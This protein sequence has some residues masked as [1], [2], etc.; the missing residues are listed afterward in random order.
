MPLVYERAFGGLGEAN[1][2]GVETPNV[3]DPADPRNPVSFAPISPYW[4]ARK[5][6][7][8]RT[9]RR[10]FEG[11]PAEVPDGI[12]WE[13]FQAAPPD[14]QTDHL[15]GG[16]WLVLDGVHPTL[17]RVQ[18]RLPTARGVARVLV[19]RPGA[20]PA[21][22][23]VELACDTLTIDGEK[24]M[25]SL[26]WRGHYEV[27]GGDAA[28]SSLTVLAGLEEVNAVVD[29]AKL[30]RPPAAPA[31]G[32]SPA[33]A[34][35]AAPAEETLALGS[36]QAAAVAQRAIAP[37]AVAAA[38]TRAVPSSTAATPWSADPVRAIAAVVG[39][40]TLAP[41][42]AQSPREAVGEGTLPLR[43]EQHAALAQ[44]PIAPF[45]LAAP[46]ARGTSAAVA[47]A[48]WSGRRGHCA[49]PDRRRRR[50]DDGA[51]RPAWP[52]QSR[53]AAFGA[54]VSVRRAADTG[55][56]PSTPGAE[57]RAARGTGVD[58]REV[59]RSRRQPR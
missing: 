2:V 22:H 18:T 47:G 55:D 23:V 54:R 1:P 52:V 13:Y 25:I 34:K 24:Q 50:G 32:A 45:Q 7:L 40:V 11:A 27:A 28:L 46:G 31:S 30:A 37:F 36:E 44:Q 9:D 58:C 33:I 4:P 49:S 8:G 5:R 56:A 12:A 14:Q 39:E 6:L 35:G 38:G 57:G 53:A 43:D 16:E 42:A 21:E 3:V 59:A 15:R 48:P 20:A 19:R 41:T 51:G 29:W 17:P 26:V 10:V